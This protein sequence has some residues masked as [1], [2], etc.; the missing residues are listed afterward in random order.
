MRKIKVELLCT[1]CGYLGQPSK[2][3]KGSAASE[4]ILWLLFIFP[5]LLYS[6]WR[7]YSKYEA[8]PK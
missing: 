7:V 4:L 2:V 5:G 1:N 8:C 6:M 3:M